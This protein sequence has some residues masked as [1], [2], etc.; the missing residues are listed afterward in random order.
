M[1]DKTKIPLPAVITDCG[2]FI[3][4]DS[5]KNYNFCVYP[6]G[7]RVG[8]LS[9]P[10]GE[11]PEEFAIRLH[12]YGHLLL[13]SSGFHNT[14][15]L[16]ILKD[17]LLYAS[18]LQAALDVIV[19]HYL[20]RI[21]CEEISYLPFPT[22]NTYFNKALDKALA[23]Q[24]FLRSSGLI[25]EEEIKLEMVKFLVTNYDRSD[26]SF[27]ETANEKLIQ[28]NRL[29]HLPVKDFIALIQKLE[30]TFGHTWEGPSNWGDLIT[31]KKAGFTYSTS[32]IDYSPIFEQ[33]I[34]AQKETC[35]DLLN[36]KYQERQRQVSIGITK[37]IMRKSNIEWSDGWWN[38]WGKME[39]AHL[40]LTEIHPTRKNARKF[41]PGFVGAF[42]YPHRALLPAGDGAAFTHRQKAK[43]G[44]IL[45][46]CSGSMGLPIKDIDNLL[47]RAPMLTVACYAGNKDI[48][49][50]SLAIFIK[51]GILAS[52]HTVE[53][54]YE[55]RCGGNIIDGPA[56]R[57]LIKQQQ[58]RIWI[59]D[60]RVTGIDDT[61]AKNLNL[62]AV[63]LKKFGK[64]KQF[65]DIEACLKTFR[66]E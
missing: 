1:T 27:L 25:G 48:E 33:T 59:S 39:M 58:P 40:P 31:N 44:T 15:L 11:K 50:G 17:E 46:D 24:T 20:L 55:E 8:I 22:I 26:I 6:D 37:G 35:Y 2:P 16:Q 49:T 12:E 63:I 66:V 4:L 36:T 45:L 23:A 29:R 51:N 41:L 32:S 3:V 61:S 28:W 64:I 54:W 47:Y 7:D 60:G 18:W 13:I 57:W 9:V 56:L 5:K 52:K 62:E 53:N 38:N 42:R 65:I 10:L 34:S 21:K 19:N 30:Q 14:N 43:G